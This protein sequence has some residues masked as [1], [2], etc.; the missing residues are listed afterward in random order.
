[1]TQ[2]L[3]TAFAADTM[4]ARGYEVFEGPLRDIRGGAADSRLVKPH[5]LFTAFPGENVDGNRFV[6]DALRAGAVAAIC[7]QRPAGEWPDKTI[8]VTPDTTR[9]VAEL[10]QA[11]RRSVAPRVI[12][13]TGTVGKTTAKDLVAAAVSARFRTHKSAGNFNSREGLPLALMSLEREHEVSVLELAMDSVGEIL[14]LCEI[15]EPE[16]GIV[17]NVGLTHVEKLG[18]IEAIQR[19]KLS[20]ARY[21]GRDGTAILNLDDP[22]IAPVEV[23]LDSHV[24]SFGESDGAALRRGPVTNRALEGTSFEVTY[25]GARAQVHSPVP[26]EH[27]VPAA[28]AAIGAC[29]ALGMT[30]D[31]AAI[32]VNGADVGGRARMLASD[33]GATIIDD[34]YN[35]SPA[36]LA[37]ALDMLS[38]LPGRR[39]ALLGRMAELGTF[40]ESEHR[41]AG[42]T[43]ARSCDLLVCSGPVC[44]PMAEAAAGAG[45]HEVHWFATKEEA[46]SFVREILRRGDYVLV[47]ASRGE[48]FETLLPLLEGSQ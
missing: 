19:E 45:L 43:A 34:R 44:R 23:E 33:R 27:T 48:A 32:A 6:A 3:T 13:I 35:S 22:R 37:G 29:L 15:A 2:H 12:G 7:E 9:A 17:L 1:M 25:E 20:L 14:Y 10:A 30:L 39:I 31:E 46:A 38:R 21:L 5:D 16:I 4:R 24:L 26:G 8:I 41:K 28:L 47:K 40:E 18:S 11:W 42:E 36:S